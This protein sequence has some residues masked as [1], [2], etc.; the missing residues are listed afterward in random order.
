M[1]YLLGAGQIKFRDTTDHYY[2]P[3]KFPKEFSAIKISYFRIDFKPYSYK[4][5][6]EGYEV[7][8]DKKDML[9]FISEKKIDT[10]N[11]PSTQDNTIAIMSG[12]KDTE[13]IFIIDEN[14]NKD[15]RD[16]SIRT[17]EEMDWGSRRLTEVKY[18]IYDGQKMINDSA[19]MNIG[20]IHNELWFF[21]ANH[22]V[23][24]FSIDRD[25][26]QLS[27]VDENCSFTFDE[28]IIALTARNSNIKDTLLLA[29]LLYK[30]NMLNLTTATIN[31]QKSQTMGNLL[32]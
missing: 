24:N 16:D 21:V 25:T 3:V 19:W 11:L 2:Y 22:L 1:V 14:N 13:S 4:L 30:V 9:G 28:P 12:K 8:Y 5:S 29:D 15:F 18:L 6:K 17:Y 10:L 7:Y 23:A 26:F 32:L 20:A 31:S 27:L